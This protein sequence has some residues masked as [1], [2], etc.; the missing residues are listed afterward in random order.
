MKLKYVGLKTDGESAFSPETGITWMPGDSREVRDVVAQRML[1]HP[2]V[3]AVDEA[4]DVPTAPTQSAE[5]NK[6]QLP[7]GEVRSLDGLNDDALREFAKT[8]GV[9][10]HHKA[11]G[12]KLVDAL[13]SAFP[14]TA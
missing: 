4:D 14:L 8:H 12:Q 5:Q 6:I 7:D 1:N 10:V 13:M 9:A 11:K 3:F 2:D